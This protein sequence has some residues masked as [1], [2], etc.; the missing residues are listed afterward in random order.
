MGAAFDDGCSGRRRAPKKNPTGGTPVGLS[1]GF[2][3]LWF[4][5]GALAVAGG[6]VSRS[7]FFVTLPL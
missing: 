4:F 5:F 3:Q 1:T 2:A 7:F 6:G